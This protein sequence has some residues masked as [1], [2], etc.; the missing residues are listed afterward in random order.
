MSGAKPNAYT[1]END[2]SFIIQKFEDSTDRTTADRFRCQPHRQDVEEMLAIVALPDLG[3]NE[4][5]AQEARSIIRAFDN[6]IDGEREGE[7]SIAK[8][9]SRDNAEPS[10][11]FP[12]VEY[13]HIP[14]PAVPAVFSKS[15]QRQSRPGSSHALGGRRRSAPDKVRQNYKS[16][17]IALLCQRFSNISSGHDGFASLFLPSLSEVL[18]PKRSSLLLEIEVSVVELRKKVSAMITGHCRDEKRGLELI[19]G[20][21]LAICTK[22]AS[23]TLSS[24]G[25]GVN[26]KAR[27]RRACCTWIDESGFVRCTFIGITDFQIRVQTEIFKSSCC[28]HAASMSVLV[29]KLAGITNTSASICGQALHTVHKSRFS[30]SC[31]DYF[32]DLPLFTYAQNEEVAVLALKDTIDRKILLV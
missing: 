32:S 7:F 27:Q 8:N 17:S 5:W 24:A 3:E 2:L 22:F 14:L 28:Y 30:E 6:T 4:S 31:E 1:D 20:P 16:R 12:E 23:S 13:D 25:Q 10:D 9:S 18:Q 29:E 11:V 21:T 15:L 19:Y 26:S